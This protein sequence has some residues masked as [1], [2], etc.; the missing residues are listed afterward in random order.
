MDSLA[1]R[2][3]RIETRFVMNDVCVQS[4]AT[5]RVPDV[6]EGMQAMA[7]HERKVERR[8][9]SIVGPE[10]GCVSW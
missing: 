1:E 3:L 8:L 10:W 4:V 7:H 5:T 6:L 9:R 2:G